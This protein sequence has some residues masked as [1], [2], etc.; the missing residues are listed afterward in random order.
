[1]SNRECAKKYLLDKVADWLD[2]ASEDNN[3]RSITL[4]V[5]LRRPGNQGVEI[6]LREEKLT[7]DGYCLPKKEE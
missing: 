4:F 1:M 7:G 2:H 5:T 6:R 3:Y